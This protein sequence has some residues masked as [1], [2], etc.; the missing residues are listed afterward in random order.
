[1]DGQP[2]RMLCRSITQCSSTK[3]NESRTVHE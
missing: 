1:M 3:L 2:Y